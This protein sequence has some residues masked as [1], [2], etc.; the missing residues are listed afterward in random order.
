[1]FHSF[2][3]SVVRMAARFQNVIK[4]HDVGFNIS[5]RM[6]NGIADS[7][8]AA[9]LT[10]TDGA[11]CRNTSLTVRASAMDSPDH[12]KAASIR[13]PIPDSR[14]DLLQ[15]PEFQVRIII[16]VQIVDHHDPY[17]LCSAKQPLCQIRADKTRSSCDQ[18]SFS[19]QRYVSPLSYS[20]S[21]E[22]ISCIYL[23]LHIEKAGIKPVGN[24]QIRLLLECLQV[25]YMPASGYRF[26]RFH[27]RL[28]Y[29]Q[30]QAAFP[31]VFQSH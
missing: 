8:L 27:D 7:C 26:I 3:A 19:A 14:P 31:K 23:I 15:T 6:I 11:N 29:D 5:V 17:R 22:Q 20:V 28:I 21:P 30:I 1:M 24:D 9:R 25:L 12:L 16:I 13:R 2:R 18:N 10:T 4:P